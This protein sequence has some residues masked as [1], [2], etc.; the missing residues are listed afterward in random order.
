MS[1]SKVYLIIGALLFIFTVITVALSYIDFAHIGIFKWAFGLVGL[2]GDG[3]NIV[4]GLIVATFK[5]CLVG[6]W[7]MHLKQETMQIWRPLLFTFFF[8]FALFMLFVLAYLDPIP[9]SSH[10]FH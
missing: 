9:S 5:V 10:W 8:V 1:H 4:I 7:F 6:A 3:I 2:K